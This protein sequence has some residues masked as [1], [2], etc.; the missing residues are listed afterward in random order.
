MGFNT[1]TSDHV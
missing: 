1:P